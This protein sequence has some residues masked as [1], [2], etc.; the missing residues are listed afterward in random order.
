VLTEII[1]SLHLQAGIEAAGASA[2]RGKFGVRL[3]L[4]GYDL[5]HIREVLG[6]ATLTEAKSLAGTD[7]VD[8]GRTVAK[9]I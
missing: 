1:P 8:L 5:R 6:P 2:A 7:P 3:H 9:A 4:A